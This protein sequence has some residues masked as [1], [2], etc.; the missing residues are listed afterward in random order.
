M[1]VRL[2]AA[3]G[4]L[5]LLAACSSPPATFNLTGA[6]V[7]P[8]YWCPG[9]STDA[10]YTVHAS[11]KARN[12]TSKEVTIESATAEMVLTAVSGTWL[13]RVGQRYDAGTVDISPSTV[14]AHATAT[15][16]ASIPSTC[17][18]ALYGAGNS[19]TGT[20]EVRIHLV[21]SAGQFT[22]TASNEHQ[23]LAA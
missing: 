1:N 21:T 10:A 6:T 9:G 3:L 11:L 4:A 19:S 5:V 15:L 23:I 16:N 17:T 12:D 14:A 18:S 22:I 7:D 8:A 13:E 20:Y 2:T